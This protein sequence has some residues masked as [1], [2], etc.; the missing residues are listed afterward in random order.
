MKIENN[1]KILILIKMLFNRKNNKISNV[2]VNV[3]FRFGGQ[4]N[5]SSCSAAAALVA[6]LNQ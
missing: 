4:V 6:A 3:E 2:N 5:L 1:W